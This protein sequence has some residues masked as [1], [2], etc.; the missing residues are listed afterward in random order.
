M[1]ER[2]QAVAD[3]A[4]SKV[5]RGYIFGATGWV[6]SPARRRQQA[7]QYPQHAARIL[8]IGARWDGIQCFDCA[9]L[10]RFSVDAAG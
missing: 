7:A 3:Y 9:Q 1:D 8:G 10:T 4:L 2:F 5:G 6:C